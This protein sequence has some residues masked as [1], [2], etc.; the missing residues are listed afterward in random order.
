MDDWA[1]NVLKRGRAAFTL[2]ELLLVIAIM[3]VLTAVILP[4]FSVG[5]SGSRVRTATLAYMQSARYARTMALLYQ[6]EVQIVC[7]TGGVIRV[8]AGTIRGE[9]HG[10]FKIPD[11]VANAQES[12]TSQQSSKSSTKSGSSTRTT[13]TR[14]TT[15]TKS[16]HPAGE[17]SDD[18]SVTNDVSAEA[19]ASAGDVTEAIRAGQTFEGVHVQFLEYTDE[20]PPVAGAPVMNETESF[21]VN[22]RS[23]GTCR[24]Y[25]VRVSD[26][27]GVELILNVDMLGATEVEG[28]GGE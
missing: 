5:M 25:R 9:G 17:S 7:E 16:T 11:E 21:R 8:E 20:A 28:E 22:F 14:T 13:P 4:Q 1:H 3:G 26:D 12:A 18:A 23:N 15:S 27:S 6:I 2:I 19:L 10:P 24:P